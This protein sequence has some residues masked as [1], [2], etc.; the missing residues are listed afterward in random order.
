VLVALGTV[1]SNL[2]QEEQAVAYFQ[3]S[4]AVFQQ[5]G[6]RANGAMA[7]NMLGRLAAW[8]YDFSRAQYY[9]TQALTWYQAIGQPKGE[10]DTQRYLAD[11]ALTLG[12]YEA[13][14]ERLTA[15]LETY[16]AIQEERSTGTT[17]ARLALAHHYLGDQE[18]AVQQAEAAL[19][20][21]VKVGNPL[22]RAYG[23]SSLGHGLRG[24]GEWERATAVYIEAIALW[25]ELDAL[26]MKTEL[27]AALAAVYYAAGQ[28]E[29]AWPLLETA[30]AYLVDNPQ[31][32]CDALGQLYLDCVTLLR[33][34]GENE[35]ADSLRQQ[36]VA[37]LRRQADGIAD[38]E[39]RGRF[40]NGVLAHRQLLAAQPIPA[41]VG[42]ALAKRKS[43][44]G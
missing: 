7:A 20:I 4:L 36:A 38:A 40:L 17:L 33:A 43:L 31:T 22:L 11:L 2:D 30:V 23:L 37:T 9:Y 13:A 5:M 25:H 6:D 26:G 44:P 34:K 16:R 19:A 24:Q 39:I 1:A 10:A 35:Q 27:Q 8:D 42:L 21:A 12:Q 18:T 15:V 41:G 28:T 29:A 32:D 3:E 14:R